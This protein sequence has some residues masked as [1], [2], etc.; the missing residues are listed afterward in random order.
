MTS[1]VFYAEMAKE[2]GIIPFTLKKYYLYP[3]LLLG[4]NPVSQR[5]RL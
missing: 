5:L 2:S 4:E 3:L 1:R